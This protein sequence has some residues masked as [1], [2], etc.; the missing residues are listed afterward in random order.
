MAAVNDILLMWTPG[1]WEIALI[2]GALLLLFGGKKLPE[3]ARGLGRGMREFR[4]E[5]KGTKKELED[6]STFDTDYHVE[7]EDREKTGR[8]ETDQHNA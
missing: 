1:W 6:T 4:D 2:L 3:L 8:G 7:E 5:L